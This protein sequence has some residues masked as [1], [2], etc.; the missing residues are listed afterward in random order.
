ML[1]GDVVL[2]VKAK[3][4][5]QETGI[6]LSASN[7]VCFM[8]LYAMDW[9][10][11][12]DREEQRTNIFQKG[13]IL[14]PLLLH[15]NLVPSRK[16]I[17]VKGSTMYLVFSIRSQKPS[18]TPHTPS[19][20]IQETIWEVF[21]NPAL[22]SQGFYS[23]APAYRSSLAYHCA[24]ELWFAAVLFHEFCLCTQSLFL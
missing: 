13:Y 23:L 12:V 6:S 19:P 16:L 15:P 24:H 4:I 11:A 22:L 5:P 2:L 9:W 18:S 3:D 7:A 17:S 14:T 21:S 8:H 20:Q 10:N 1:H